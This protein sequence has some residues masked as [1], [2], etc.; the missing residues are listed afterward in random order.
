MLG[1]LT[2]HILSS[3]EPAWE[4]RLWGDSITLKPIL[5]T[6]VPGRIPEIFLPKEEELPGQ[7]V[8]PLR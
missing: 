6:L 8:S 7:P 2:P 5:E 4:T 3:N 1:K